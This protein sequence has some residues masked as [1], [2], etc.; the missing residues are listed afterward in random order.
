MTREEILQEIARLDREINKIAGATRL[1]PMATARPPIGSIITSAVFLG[2]WAAGAAISAE[3][4]AKTALWA[5]IIGALAALAAL[6]GLFNW[7]KGLLGRGNQKKF[8]ANM[9]AA[10]A[11]QQ[12]RKLLQEQ[13]ARMPK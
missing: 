12:Q 13:L 1:K 8:G 4:H 5:L 6:M 11:L 9:E 10:A 2:Y 3:L 7:I